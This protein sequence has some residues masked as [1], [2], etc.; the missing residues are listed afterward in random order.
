MIRVANHDQIAEVV[1]GRTFADERVLIG[2]VIFQATHGNDV[3]RG[4][5]PA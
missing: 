1:A 3:F 2:T 4:S 5:L